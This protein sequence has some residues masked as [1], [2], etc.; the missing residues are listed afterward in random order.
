LSHTPLTP[1]SFSTPSPSCDWQFA[2]AEVL[3]QKLSGPAVRLP[4]PVLQENGC[5]DKEYFGMLA[6]RKG[7]YITNVPPNFGE[8]HAGTTES[9]RERERQTE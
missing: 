9:E 4:P 3:V 6:A 1:L 2:T 7:P 5:I 8:D